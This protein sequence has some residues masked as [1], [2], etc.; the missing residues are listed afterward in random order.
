MI[1][2]D[3]NRWVRELAEVIQCEEAAPYR[4]EILD[5]LKDILRLKE[6]ASDLA[7]KTRGVG[8]QTSRDRCAGGDR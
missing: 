3:L 2:P 8:A 4:E 6:I 7:S 5:L 1:Y